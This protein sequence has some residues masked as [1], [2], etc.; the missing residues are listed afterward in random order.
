MKEKASWDQAF[1]LFCSLTPAGCNWLLPTPVFMVSFSWQYL[2]WWVKRN[3]SSFELVYQSI[4][5]SE[6]RKRNTDVLTVVLWS[7][8]RVPTSFILEIKFLEESIWGLNDLHFPLLKCKLISLAMTCFH[9]PFGRKDVSQSFAMILPLLLG[10][11]KPLMDHVIATEYGFN[12]HPLDLRSPWKK[13]RK[14]KVNPV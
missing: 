1:S 4:S 13:R 8:S 6:M 9:Q 11:Q 14:N 2:I 12:F 7:S 5:L 3:I 10:Y